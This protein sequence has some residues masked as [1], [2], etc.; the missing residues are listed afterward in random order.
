LFPFPFQHFGA[1]PLLCGGR[2]VL[3]TGGAGYIGTHT[4]VA[5]QEAGYDV[6]VRMLK[7]QL[8]YIENK[9]NFSILT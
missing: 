1:E 8:L 3:I 6:M 4:A 9:Q 7:K 5:L 2:T